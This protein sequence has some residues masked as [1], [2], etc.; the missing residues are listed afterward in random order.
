MLLTPFLRR[1]SSLKL[2]SYER[3]RPPSSEVAAKTFRFILEELC[4]AV[5]CFFLFIFYNFSS[6][7]ERCNFAVKM[8]KCFVEYETFPDCVVLL[9]IHA[10]RFLL[11]QLHIKSVHLL[12]HELTF[13]MK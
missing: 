11:L 13:I 12:Q 5:L 3:Y 6:S 10:E 8:Q 7:G 1:E 9:L 2:L 4:G